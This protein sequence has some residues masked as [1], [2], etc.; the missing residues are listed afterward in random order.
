LDNLTNRKDNCDEDTQLDLELG[1]G[2]KASENPVHRIVSAGPNVPGLIQPTWRSMTQAEKG[3][4]S[5][6]AMETMRSKGNKKK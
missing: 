4:M 6:S 1:N 2:I 5:V 3:L